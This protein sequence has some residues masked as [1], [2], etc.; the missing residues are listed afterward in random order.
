MGRMSTIAPLPTTGA[1]PL[2]ALVVDDDE[3][4][5]KLMS[6]M[7]KGLGVQN[8]A[9]AC[10][11]AAGLAAYDSAAAKPEVVLCDLNMPDTDG[12][13]FMEK[14]ADRQ[15]K[16]GI[17][18]VSGTTARVRSSASLMGRFHRLNVLGTLE[19]P[20]DRAS[21]AEALAKIA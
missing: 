12:F 8:V 19:K 11:G 6:H 15:Y 10:D 5:V 4:M 20:V 3:L 14:M 16:G 7:L 1:F 9:T 13:Q 21:L 18:L 2:N 17:I